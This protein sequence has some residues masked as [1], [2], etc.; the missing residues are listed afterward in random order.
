MVYKRE[1]QLDD[2]FFALSHPVRR[3]MI[4]QLSETDM[5]VASLALEHALSKAQI[6]KHV[7]ILERSGLLARSKVG[8]Q[9]KL[10]LQPNGLQKVDD[11]IE[12]FRHF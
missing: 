5:S 11:W 7:H 12:H 4:N 8:R 10:S 3:R 6:T 9:H 1:Q 2:V